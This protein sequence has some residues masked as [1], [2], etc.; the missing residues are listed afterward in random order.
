MYYDVTL[1]RFR[2]IIVTVEEQYVFH[3]LSVC[4]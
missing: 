3:I 4:L 2:V 1:R